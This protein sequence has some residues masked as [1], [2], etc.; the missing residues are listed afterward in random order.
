MA[1]S[2]EIS[3]FP[4]QVVWNSNTWSNTT[5]GVM[6]MDFGVSTETANFASGVDVFDSVAIADSEWPRVSLGGP[7][8]V[9]T[10]EIASIF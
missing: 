7:T 8:S 9:T 10:D 3:F 5:G 1:I 6:R 4:K 2:D